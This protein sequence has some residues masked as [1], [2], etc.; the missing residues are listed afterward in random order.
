MPFLS[1]FTSLNPTTDHTLST[2]TSQKRKSL[3]ATTEKPTK[4][5]RGRFSSIFALGSLVGVGIGNGESRSSPIPIPSTPKGPRAMPVSSGAPKSPPTCTISLENATSRGPLESLNVNVNVNVI[6]FPSS[7]ATLS[8]PL[9]PTKL[10]RTRSN[11]LLL[12][13]STPPATRGTKGHRRHHSCS[14]VAEIIGNGQHVTYDRPSS[15]VTVPYDVDCDDDDDQVVIDLPSFMGMDI[16]SPSASLVRKRGDAKLVAMVKRSLLAGVREASYAALRANVSSSVD[17]SCTLVSS[18]SGSVTYD[19]LEDL[20]QDTLHDRQDF[21]EQDRILIHR[22]N[23]YLHEWGWREKRV[24]PEYPTFRACAEID[25]EEN[26]SASQHKTFVAALADGGD[27]FGDDVDAM[28]V[29]I[30]MDMDDSPVESRFAESKRF[31]TPPP[32]SLPERRSSPPPSAPPRVE[33]TLGLDQLVATLTMKHRDRLGARKGG[34]KS[35]RTQ[36]S[37]LKVEL[38]L[39]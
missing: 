15:P 8:P 18:T 36:G 25:L 28:D 20:S 17:S 29:D 38:R 19:F 33:R 13:K 1:S 35:E 39:D 7:S 37:S 34:W 23:A 2:G 5:A 22:L 11:H 16:P 26:S 4:R 3:S 30:D 31:S 14:C 24:L 27:V 12:R 21:M 6:P 10:S 9:S 32:P